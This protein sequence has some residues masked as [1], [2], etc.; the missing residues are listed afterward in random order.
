[1]TALGTIRNEKTEKVPESQLQRDKET[2]L[3]AF[4]KTPCP[5][6][7]HDFLRP[8]PFRC[9]KCG[10]PLRWK[11]AEIERYMGSYFD[12]TGYR[13]TNQMNAGDIVFFS[14]S[15]GDKPVFEAE[16]DFSTLRVR[17]CLHGSRDGWMQRFYPKRF[18]TPKDIR[19]RK[20]DA[21]KLKRYL[22]DCDFSTWETPAHYVVNHGAPGFHVNARFS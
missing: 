13:W 2:C 15:A 18:F 5:N 4:S 20:N 8:Y 21:Q 11:E 16:C 3:P 1:M 22:T 10:L 9:R 12:G 7:S 14:I 19:L 6:N 17:N